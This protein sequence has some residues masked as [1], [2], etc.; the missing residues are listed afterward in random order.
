VRSSELLAE[1][2]KDSVVVSGERKIADEYFAR[3]DKAFRPTAAGVA[4]P[5]GIEDI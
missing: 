1:P 4:L 5:F 2:F 3:I